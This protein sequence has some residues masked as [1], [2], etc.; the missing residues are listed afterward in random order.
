MSIYDDEFRELALDLLQDTKS[1]NYT[2]V[3][4]GE[5]NIETGE[6]VNTTSNKQIKGMFSSVSVGDITSGLATVTD[7]KITIAALDIE[8]PKNG[9]LIDNKYTVIYAKP[10]YSGDLIAYFDLICKSS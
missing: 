3:I 10:Q 2:Q 6:M 9:D 8:N 4:N 5:Y 7:I 1:I